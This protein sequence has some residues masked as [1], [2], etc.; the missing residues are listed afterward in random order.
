MSLQIPKAKNAE[1]LV[2]AEALFQLVA[3]CGQ[4]G[5]TLAELHKHSGLPRSTVYRVLSAWQYLEWLE[6]STNNGRSECWRVSDKLLKFAHQHRRNALSQTTQSHYFPMTEDEHMEF[7][8]Q[9]KQRSDV[10]VKAVN[11]FHL[12]A[13]KDLAGKTLDELQYLSGYS[14]S[15]TYRLLCTWE[16]L[17][18]LKSIAVDGRTEKWFISSK[19]LEL[20]HQH[21]R[22]TLAQVK[23][24]ETDYQQM[25]GEV[26]I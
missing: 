11:L 8:F 4:R 9:K 25:T 20:A 19:L 24:I 2:K 23:K 1:T 14:R 15:T 17:G 21:R 12:V 26:L 16:R 5:I 18:W 3:E 7:D 6:T 13:T 10:A 22:E